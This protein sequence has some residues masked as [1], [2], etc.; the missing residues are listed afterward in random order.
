MY[1]FDKYKILYNVFRWIAYY[2]LD[3]RFFMKFLMVFSLITSIFMGSI[4]AMEYDADSEGLT[5]IDFSLFSPESNN[6]M[7][8]YGNNGYE[9]EIDDSLFIDS[10]N[11]NNTQFAQLKPKQNT[12]RNYKKRLR[13]YHGPFAIYVGLLEKDLLKEKKWEPSFEY[14]KHLRKRLRGTKRSSKLS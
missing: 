12:Q 10:V 8:E 7:V 1:S 6:N 4:F 2:F 9:T 11:N 13:S 3:G 5:D 14:K